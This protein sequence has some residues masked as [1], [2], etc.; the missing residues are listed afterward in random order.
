MRTDSLFP[1]IW[2]FH[3]NLL[4]LSLSSLDRLES[5]LPVL[6]TQPRLLEITARLVTIEWDAWNPEAGDPGDPPITTYTVYYRP[7]TGESTDWQRG[8]EVPVTDSRMLSAT[9]GNLVPDT[10]H[11]VGVTVSREGVGGEGGIRLTLSVKTLCSGKP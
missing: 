8:V 7:E 9:V 1:G 2:H 6:R 11:E 5:E 3:L 4:S 10:T